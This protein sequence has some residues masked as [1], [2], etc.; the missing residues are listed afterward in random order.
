MSAPPPL[1]LMNTYLATGQDALTSLFA[2]TS[3][4]QRT[5]GSRHKTFLSNMEA[6][7]IEISSAS[8]GTLCSLVSAV[9]ELFETALLF[10]N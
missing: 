6:G 7:R 4:L 9:I 3:H 5:P 1:T 10:N 2:T 8:Y